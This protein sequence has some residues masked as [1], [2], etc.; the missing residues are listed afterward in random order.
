MLSLLLCLCICQDLASEELSATQIQLSD[1]RDNHSQINSH[2]D[3]DG[4]ARF[5][6]LVIG[7]PPEKKVWI[8][9]DNS[10]IYVDVDGDKFLDEP[11][12]RVPYVVEDDVNPTR[13]DLPTISNLEFRIYLSR[14]VEDADPEL[15]NLYESHDFAPAFLSVRNGG[16][17]YCQSQLVLGTELAEAQVVWINGVLKSVPYPF[18]HSSISSSG[19]LLR[20]KVVSEQLKPDDFEPDVVTLYFARYLFRGSPDATIAAKV[21][22]GDGLENEVILDRRFDK[23]YFSGFFKPTEGASERLIVEFPELRQRDLVLRGGKYEFN[24]TNTPDETLEKYRA[25]LQSQ[26][27]DHQES[28]D[29]LK[30]KLELLGIKQADK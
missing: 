22:Y 3:Y 7:N 26:I 19:T 21:H 8:A 29:D 13:V 17:P 6:L 1:I 28:I 12:E 14:W 25:N 18:G 23:N 15:R 4:T 16:E 2:P 9:V 10:S 5:C 20:T 11:H 30:A 27:N 24:V